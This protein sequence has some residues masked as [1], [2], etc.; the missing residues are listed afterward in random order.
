M[1][2]E[3]IKQLIEVFSKFPGIGERTAERLSFHIINYEKEE[4]LQIVEIINKVKN[5]KK[6]EICNNLTEEKI[7]YICTDKERESNI[8]CIVEDVKNM[9]MF[10]KIASFNGKYHILEK[11]ISPLNAI[12]PEDLNIEKIKERIKKEKI[13]EV[14]IALKSTIEGETTALY[15]NKILGKEKVVITKLAQG[16]PLGTD[17]EYLDPITLETAITNR[18][19]ISE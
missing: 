4:I 14:I 7:C 12:G 2:P 10:E 17:M 15:L 16:V 11:L 8:M 1:Y 19:I 13:K 3:T 9:I 18:K 5:I 6:C